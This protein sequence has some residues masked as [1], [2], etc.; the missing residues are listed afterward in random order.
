MKTFLSICALAGA[1]LLGDAAVGRWTD[2]NIV[3][4]QTT[5]SA[6]YQNCTNIRHWPAAQCAQYC[7]GKSKRK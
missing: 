1:L 5:S 2:G 3:M 6:C 7:K 4:A